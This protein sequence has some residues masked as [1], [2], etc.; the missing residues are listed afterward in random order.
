MLEIQL[1]RREGWDPQLCACSK[2]GP[3]FPTSYVMFP[4]NYFQSSMVKYKHPFN[5]FCDILNVSYPR[6]YRRDLRWDYKYIVQD[7][8]IEKYMYI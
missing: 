1:S 3:G 2:L 5:F 8:P 7:I 6:V 4:C